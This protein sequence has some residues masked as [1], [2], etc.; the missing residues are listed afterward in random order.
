MI[1]IL[2]EITEWDCYKVNNGF[3]HINGAGQLVAHQPEG[4]ELKVFKT[5]I[6]NFS[7]S[8][9][10][11]LKVGDYQEKNNLGGIPVKGSNG[12]TYYIVDGKCS[13]KGFQFRGDCK[14]IRSLAA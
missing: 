12:N 1:E 8:R 9:R 3:Y 14:H 11:F 2:K 13:C 10:K 6:K 5:P 4:G 7:K